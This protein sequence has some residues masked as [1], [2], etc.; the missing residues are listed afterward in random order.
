MTAHISYCFLL[1]KGVINVLNVSR[2]SFDNFLRSVPDLLLCCLNYLVILRETNWLPKS[3]R[4][5]NIV[6]I[7]DIY[8]LG[9]WIQLVILTS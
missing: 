2:I 1:N 4:D 3:P 6:E 7:I 9:T 8:G 5:V